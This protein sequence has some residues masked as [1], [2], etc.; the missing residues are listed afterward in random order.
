MVA[1]V[2]LTWFSTAE[3]V[4]KNYNLNFW[5]GSLIFFELVPLIV[6]SFGSLL[7]I[8]ASYYMNFGWPFYNNIA[9]FSFQWFVNLL[10]KKD[11]FGLLWVTMG[12][13]GLERIIA[14]WCLQKTLTASS[15]VCNILWKSSVY[16][17][18]TI[19]S[20][21]FELITN[22]IDIFRKSTM[23]KKKIKT[24]FHTSV[25]AWENF[26]SLPEENLLTMRNEI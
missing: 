10:T 16:P 6:V 9:N 21:P 13:F 26:Y 2:Y 23:I 20:F 14:W 3:L 8:F 12:C 15:S 4:P 22:S 19:K 24:S 1:R 5:V 25:V 11:I 17:S 18:W 7:T